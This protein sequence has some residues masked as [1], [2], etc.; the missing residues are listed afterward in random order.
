MFPFCYKGVVPAVFT[1]LDYLETYLSPASLLLTNWIL[2]IKLHLKRTLGVLLIQL[3]T[4]LLI[5]IIA[6]SACSRERTP[7]SIVRRLKRQGDSL[8]MK[9]FILYVTHKHAAHCRSET[10]YRRSWRGTQ[11]L[12]LQCILPILQKDIVVKD[13]VVKQHPIKH[14]A[15]NGRVG[16]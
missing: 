16:T 14:I 2:G 8:G 4:F 12:L 3:I 15:T 6:C 9:C 13:I 5:G 7:K 1:L 11:P 10:P